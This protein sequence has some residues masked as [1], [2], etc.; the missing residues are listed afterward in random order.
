MIVKE[1][2]DAQAVEG[3][4]EEIVETVKVAPPVPQV[5]EQIV[6]VAKAA[7]AVTCTAPAPVV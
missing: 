7:H 1:I 5:Q 2:P 6:D 4:C 3:T